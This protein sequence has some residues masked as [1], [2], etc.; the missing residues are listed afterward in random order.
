MTLPER[1]RLRKYSMRQAHRPIRR[2]GTSRPAIRSAPA[3]SSLSQL[4]KNDEAPITLVVSHY[5]CSASTPKALNCQS[6]G[7]RGLLPRNP[8]IVVDRLINPEG[9]APVVR[10]RVATA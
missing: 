2:L 1:K 9:L 10:E 5:A 4:R 8:G 7:F 6:P 3:G